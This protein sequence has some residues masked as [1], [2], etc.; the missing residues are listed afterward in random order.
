MIAKSLR[1]IYII[2]YSLFFIYLFEYL[3]IDFGNVL[4]SFTPELM[5]IYFFIGLF[6]YGLF[7]K[8]T[9][10][11]CLISYSYIMYLIVIQY[12]NIWKTHSYVSIEHWYV[13]E[14]SIN[15]KIILFITV[16]IVFF[17]MYLLEDKDSEIFLNFEFLSIV[18]L[19]MSGI[20]I[21]L[22]SNNLFVM[23][24]GIELQSLATYIL[25]CWKRFSIK[26]VEAGL[27]YFIYGSFASLILLLG[28][29]LIFLFLGTLNFNE[30]NELIHTAKNTNDSLWLLHLGLIFILVGFFFKL[31]VAPFHWWL[32]E[33]FEGSPDIIAFFLAIVPKLPFFFVL[34]RL[35]ICMYVNFPLYSF[36]FIICGLLSIIIGSILALYTIKMK[37]LFAYSS[38]V[39]I[40]YMI[41]ILGLGSKI[42]IFISFY[43]F[44]IYL[45]L[46]IYLF[47]LYLVIKN[48]HKIVFSNIT[49]LSYL[50]NSNKLLPLIMVASLLSLAGIPPFMGFYGKLLIFN[51]L[52]SSGNYFICLLLLLLSILSCIYYLRLIRFIYF[53][54]RT[55]VYVVYQKNKSRYIYV[56]LFIII[57]F[58]LNLIF[59]FF[60]EPFLLYLMYIFS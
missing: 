8:M 20:L 17:F 53:N 48:S 12:Y 43:Y 60:Q 49:D 13:D 55:I 39:H 36:I 19:C 54:E 14:L 21:F 34:Y 32:V 50:K 42:G 9:S 58:L 18:L 16:F 28:I 2:L 46:T 33:V 30:L 22:S 56:F 3:I 10:F 40:G 52:I 6:I 5:F 4:Y 29:S 1:F 27:K 59:L 38:I 24:L 15:I 44:L 23:Y 26:S 31:A 51:S 47:S 37:K 41:L 57:F 25:C 11:H 7:V 35:N 45:L